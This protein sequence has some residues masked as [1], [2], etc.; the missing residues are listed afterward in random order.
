MT[1][2][3]ALAVCHAY[4]ESSQTT[5]HWDYTATAAQCRVAALLTTPGGHVSGPDVLGFTCPGPSEAH[6]PSCP[7]ASSQAR[8]CHHPRGSSPPKTRRWDQG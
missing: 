7:C 4:P 6:G 8:Q 2:G 1:W 5:K 3:S